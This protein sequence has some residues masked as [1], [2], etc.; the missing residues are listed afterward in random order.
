[1]IIP[2]A[3]NLKA[4]QP[5]PHVETSIG[6]ALTHD[7]FSLCIYTFVKKMVLQEIILV[8]ALTMITMHHFEEQREALTIILVQA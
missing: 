4:F 8:R 5:V 7:F 2:I 3:G 6:I 1:M